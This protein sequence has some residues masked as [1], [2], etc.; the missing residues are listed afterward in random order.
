[1]GG[2]IGKKKLKGERDRYINT[3][4]SL[5][6]NFSPL[7]S[8]YYFRVSLLMPLTCAVCAFLI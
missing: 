5:F 3:R 6:I 7:E 8:Y 1:M 4:V 2:R